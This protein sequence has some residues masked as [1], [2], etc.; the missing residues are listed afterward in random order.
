LSIGWRCIGTYGGTL[1]SQL[2][3]A[4]TF[5]SPRT[6]APSCIVRPN[7]VTP[8]AA[9]LEKPSM[10]RTLVAL[11]SAVPSGVSL[12]WAPVMLSW[13]LVIVTSTEPMRAGIDESATIWRS[14]ITGG[15]GRVT[16]GVALRSH[17]PR[18]L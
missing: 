4:F 8:F 13:R 16:I 11:L 17:M 6:A 18:L 2:P 9:S 3:S 15:S 1:A 10:T 5:V 7:I 12:N 14:P